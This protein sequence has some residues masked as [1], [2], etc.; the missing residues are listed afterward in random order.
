MGA[1]SLSLI[2]AAWDF[3]GAEQPASIASQRNKAILESTGFIADTMVSIQPQHVNECVNVNIWE[4]FVQF[5]EQA[6]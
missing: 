2:P 6:S 3:G 1:R 4:H 5:S